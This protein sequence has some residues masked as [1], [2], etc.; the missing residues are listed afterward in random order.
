MARAY[1]GIIDFTIKADL[2]FHM[3]H[4]I[5]NDLERRKEAIMYFDDIQA[6]VQEMDDITSII[7][8][9]PASTKKNMTMIFICGA[10]ELDCYLSLNCNISKWKVDRGYGQS[11]RSFLPT[12]NPLEA[13]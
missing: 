9:L 1:I 11:C 7:S 13:L 4:D 5:E 6:E 8:G 10:R 2:I 3:K 12:R